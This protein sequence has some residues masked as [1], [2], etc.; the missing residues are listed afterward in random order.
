LHICGIVSSPELNTIALGGVATGIMKA[1]LAPIAMGTTRSIGLTPRPTA[2]AARIG[3]RTSPIHRRER[4]C[5]SL[6]LG[7][8]LSS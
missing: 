4:A 1:Q 6:F 7:D 3:A 5:S 8:V 2:T